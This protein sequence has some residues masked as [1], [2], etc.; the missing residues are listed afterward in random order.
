MPGTAALEY[1]DP[2]LF[3][4]RTEITWPSLTKLLKRRTERGDAVNI[5]YHLA[6]A[7]VPTRKLRV[8]PSLRG[9]NSVEQ[10]HPRKARIVPDA[11]GA[12]DAP[13]DPRSS[14]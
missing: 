7:Q 9:Q 5:D 11:L 1:R 6:R 12:V 13:L 2:A 10:A 3:F 4:Y 14:A 8:I